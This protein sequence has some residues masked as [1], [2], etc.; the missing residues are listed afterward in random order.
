ML[1][2]VLKLRR[3]LAFLLNKSHALWAAPGVNMIS[4][5]RPVLKLFCIV[6]RYSRLRLRPCLG[7]APGM[8][9]PN[10]PSIKAAANSRL[11]VKQI[12]CYLAAPG[13]KAGAI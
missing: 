1:I 9:I 10:S 12:P 3:I 7:L 4:G 13:A 2:L 5:P 8:L 11:F 6:Y